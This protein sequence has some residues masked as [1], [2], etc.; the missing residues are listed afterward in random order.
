MDKNYL[1]KEILE[2]E[3]ERS[4]WTKV[5]R[6][7]F[8]VKQINQIPQLINRDT[9]DWN[10]YVENAYELGRLYTD[11]GE[12]EVGIFEVK[13]TSNPKIA[14]NRVKLRSLLSNIYGNV[15]GALI[16]FTQDDKWRFSYVSEILDR[17]AN[18]NVI[19]V[20]T[21]PKRYTYFFGKG[22]NC[23]TAADRFDKLKGKPLTL[24]DLTEAFSVEKLSKEFFKTY[25]EHF[26]KFWKYLAD[27]ESYYNLLSDQE[28]DDE[29]KRTKPIR[30]FVK[31]L[32]GRMVFL[33][34]LQKKG[35]M[36]VPMSRSDYK[37]G[38]LKF[39]QNL[40]AR[41]ADK[42]HFHSTALRTLFFETLNKKRPNDRA[43]E[44]LGE[45]IKIP[46]LNGGLFDKDVSAEHAI[47]FP[48]DY[49]RD[50]LNFFEQYNFTIDESDAFDREVGI[51]PEMLGHIFENLLE[52]NREKG[53]FYTPKEI[54]HYMCQESLIE[55]L[56]TNLSGDDRADIEL[57]VRHNV[58]AES[59]QNDYK[60]ATAINE[61]LKAVKICDPAIG[62]GAFPMGLLKEMFECRRLLFAPTKSENFSAA[63]I[64]K[65]I[66]QNNIHGVDIELGA[67][68]IARLRFWLSLDR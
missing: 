45:S 30:D 21:E 28:K 32:L 36:G 26:E 54:V 35:W 44:S 5:L 22:E 4:E 62:S 9:S 53:A 43:D 2:A 25:K 17:D 13:L 68:D 63:Q 59:I 56:S 55:Y 46:Y 6:E 29:V 60:R 31:I 67:V 40:F 41:F 10:D 66:I 52:E 50:L 64:K 24:T 8:G 57:L 37:G 16:I 34:F 51:D 11:G 65:E 12:R 49:F 15:D 1:Q 19:S 7:W 23:R 47:D 61:L 42:N 27:D 38:D 3:Y 18:D 14:I 33:Q 39:N 58:V 20:K 48:A